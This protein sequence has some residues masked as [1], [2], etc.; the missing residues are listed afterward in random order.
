[1]S[2]LIFHGRWLLKE[3]VLLKH[4]GIQYRM[5]PN[6]QKEWLNE[7]DARHEEI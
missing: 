1:V 2:I 3:V 4:G 5:G 7:S 6:I